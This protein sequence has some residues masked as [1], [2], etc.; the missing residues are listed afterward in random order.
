MIRLAAWV[1]KKNMAFYIISIGMIVMLLWAGAYKMTGP[2]AEGIV[3]LVTNSPLIFWHFKVFGTYLG[4]DLIG[5]TEVLSGILILSGMF[6]PRAGIFGA[7]IG[8]VI[9]FVT[10]CMIITTPG[11]IT[12]VHGI[13]YMSFLG[14]FLFK[15]IISLG[16]CLYLMGYFNQKIADR[17]MNTAEQ[18]RNIAY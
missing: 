3:P 15:D 18:K 4:S 11:T 1:I 7:A 13:G 9:F 5:I 14:L 17:G 2:G 16:A 10:S 8:V 12:L 6:R